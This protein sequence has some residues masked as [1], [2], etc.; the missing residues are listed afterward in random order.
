M[1][2]FIC[3][4]DLC[5]HYVKDCGVWI[6]CTVW[7]MQLLNCQG[8]MC[9]LQLLESSSWTTAW[10]HSKQTVE[11]CPMS[12]LSA[13]SCLCQ[14][15]GKSSGDQ[16]S[17]TSVKS[18]TVCGACRQERCWKCECDPLVIMLRSGVI[19]STGARTNRDDRIALKIKW[20]KHLFSTWECLN[21]C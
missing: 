7:F 20:I 3:F 1:F 18:R 11:F 5:L 13:A 14:L 2:W 15:A 8:R 19:C 6:N 10:I 16:Q 21:H 4:I 12:S 9:M 17:G